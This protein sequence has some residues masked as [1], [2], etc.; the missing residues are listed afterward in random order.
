[1]TADGIRLGHALIGKGHPP[2]V[3]AGTLGNHNGSLERAIRLVE[4][5]AYAG[6]HAVKLQTYTAD[7]LTIDFNS[8][9]FLVSGRESPWTGRSRTISIRR[10]T[11]P[12]IGTSQS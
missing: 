1:M 6:V 5:A 10:H 2:F 3:I 8:E 11:R 9:E 7:T 4:A 12:G